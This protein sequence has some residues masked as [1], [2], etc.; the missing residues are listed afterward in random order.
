MIFAILGF[1]QCRNCGADAAVLKYGW[2]QHGK[3]KES[4]LWRSWS[5]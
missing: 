1:N 2:L 4:M 3:C 5:M